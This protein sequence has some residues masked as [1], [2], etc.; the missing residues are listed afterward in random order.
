V[1]D[2]GLTPSPE[3]A[4]RFVREARTVAQL[5]HEHI[6]PISGSAAT[7]TAPRSSCRCRRPSLRQLSRSSAAEGSRRRAVIAGRP[8]PRAGYAHLQGGPRI[9]PYKIP[10]TEPAGGTD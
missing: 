3:L 8:R 7:R 5:E 10:P 6:V 2:L 1:L 4:E 9:K